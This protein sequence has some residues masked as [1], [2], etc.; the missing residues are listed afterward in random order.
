[1][2]SFWAS[3]GPKAND[4]H[5]SERQKCRSMQRQ[6]EESDM[7][8]EAETGVFVSKVNDATDCRQSP[9]AGRDRDG[10]SRRAPGGNHPET[11][12]VQTPGLQNLGE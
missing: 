4:K 12:Y 9:P 8:V 5:P 11:P 3:V 7:K 2:R 10:D 1:M 6:R